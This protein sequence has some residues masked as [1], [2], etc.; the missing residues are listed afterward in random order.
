MHDHLVIVSTLIFSF[1]L[2]S[3]TKTKVEQ[4]IIAKICFILKQRVI[5]S[6]YSVV[7]KNADLSPDKN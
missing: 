6:K 7:V 1:K 3:A 2:I 5:I 4:V